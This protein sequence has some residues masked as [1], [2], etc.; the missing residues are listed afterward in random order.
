MCRI[1]SD[2]EKAIKN[3]RTRW[4][5]IRKLQLAHAGRRP[6]KPSAVMKEDGKLTKGP[7][8]MKLHWHGHFSKILNISSEYQEEAITEGPSQ[9]VK[10]DLDMPPTAKKLNVALHRL[11]K[12]KAGGKTEILPEMILCG[13]V[14]LWN[15]LCSRCG[16]STE[17]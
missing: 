10:W 13:A 17:L 14:E 5:S 15:R 8:E 6:V 2:A 9:P 1:A 4:R 16:R 7:D 11:K 12:G 3:G